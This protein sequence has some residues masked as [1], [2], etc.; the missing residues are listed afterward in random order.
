MK[1]RIRSHEI[2]NNRID[3][4]NSRCAVI[5]ELAVEETHDADS[6]TAIAHLRD[7]VPDRDA[8]YARR[9]WKALIDAAG[10][11]ARLR[12][13][14][15]LDGWQAELQAEGITLTRDTEASDAASHTG[16]SVTRGNVGG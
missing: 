8:D 15:H 10:R 12:G 5:R 3:R 14:W 7:V 1:S 2:R 4:S 6:Q 13:G 11:V 9:T 16:T